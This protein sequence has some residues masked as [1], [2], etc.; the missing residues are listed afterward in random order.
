MCQLFVFAQYQR[1]SKSS[2]YQRC[3]TYL[4]T[5]LNQGNT[6]CQTFL[7]LKLREGLYM[8]FG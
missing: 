4:K 5:V 2:A 7:E 1:F 8:I 3:Y 6:L